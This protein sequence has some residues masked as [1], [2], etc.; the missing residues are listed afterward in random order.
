MRRQVWFVSLSLKSNSTEKEWIHIQAIQT[1]TTP[2][3]VQLLDV[4]ISLLLRFTRD[5]LKQMKL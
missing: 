4:T 5:A 2:L 3:R 1:P